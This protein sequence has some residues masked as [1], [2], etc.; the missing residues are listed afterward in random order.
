MLL[1]ELT[2]EMKF[3]TSKQIPRVSDMVEMDDYAYDRYYKELK[4]NLSVMQQQTVIR[5]AERLKS[6]ILMVDMEV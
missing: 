3:E 2:D 6:E 1:G 5:L 4:Q